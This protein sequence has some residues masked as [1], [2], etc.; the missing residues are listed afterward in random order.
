[1]KKLTSMIKKYGLLNPDPIWR[2]WQE[3]I[4]L[5]NNW[6]YWL[7]DVVS[8]QAWLESNMETHGDSS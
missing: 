1:M 7:W 8:L 2:R 5:R 3:H 4:S 6:G